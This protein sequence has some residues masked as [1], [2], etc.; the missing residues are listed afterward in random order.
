M[1]KRIKEKITSRTFIMVLLASI[2]LVFGKISDTIWL[3]V[4][5]GFM[6]NNGAKGYSKNKHFSKK[7]IDEYDEQI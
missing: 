4:I 6:L 7:G 5:T 2:L 3:G 1:L